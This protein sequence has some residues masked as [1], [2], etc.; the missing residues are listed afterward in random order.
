MIIQDNFGKGHNLKNQATLIPYNDRVKR[1][2]K[3]FGLNFFAAIISVF[4]P[5]LHFFLV[6]LFLILAFYQGFAKYKQTRSLNLNLES[7]PI[8]TRNLDSGLG[9]LDGDM[10]RTICSSCGTKLVISE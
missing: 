10:L 5:V 2:L 3:A 6:P 9:Y 7:C 1:G 8:C 4:V